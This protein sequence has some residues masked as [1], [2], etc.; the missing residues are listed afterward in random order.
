MRILEVLQPGL[1]TTV[2]DLGRPGYQQFGIPV[3]GA[4][5]GYALRIANRLL[6]NE[7]NAAALEITMLGP[8]LRFLADT[9]IAITGGDL[10]PGI[11]GQEIPMWETVAVHMG[12]RL[13]FGEIRSGCRA[14]LAVAGGIDVPVLL[15]SRST[16]LRGQL[17]GLE[18]RR[19]KAGDVLSAGCPRKVALLGIR[20][21]GEL[22]PRYGQEIAVRVVLGPQQDYFLPESIHT[23][24]TE[25]Y[26]VTEQADRMG[27][28]LEGPRLSHIRGAD[29]VSDGIPPGAVQV[30]GHGLPI[31][32]L[33]DRQTT[34]G[35]AKIATV[36][37]SDIP[38]LAQAKPGDVIRFSQISVEAAQAILRDLEGQLTRWEINE[39]L[40]T[41]RSKKYHITVNGCIYD[42]VVRER[43]QPHF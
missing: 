10:L 22:I 27:C 30:P 38:K 34:G 15:G 2:Q 21:P 7:E 26:T 28:R 3:A 36:I 1:L 4:M 14:Y 29:I 32:M 41:E 9:T 39:P 13:G 33:A 19:L 23:F 25:P 16:Y 31:V 20:V 8:E 12:D 17:G 18:G 42:V 6:G 35:Y 11:N 5:D 37:S 24:L 43:T 40:H